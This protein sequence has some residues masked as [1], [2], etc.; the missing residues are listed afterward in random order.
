[1]NNKKILLITLL[2]LS[3]GVLFAENKDN[4]IVVP[5]INN[6]SN[7]DLLVMPTSKEDM[8]QNV[9][10]LKKATK[11]IDTFIKALSPNEQEEFNRIIQQIEQKMT[12]SDSALDLTPDVS[13]PNESE[14]AN[15]VLLLM[16]RF[17]C[18]QEGQEEGVVCQMYEC[19]NND[20]QVSNPIKINSE[21]KA[22]NDIAFPQE[23]PMFNSIKSEILTQEEPIS[24]NSA[25]PDVLTEEQPT[26][27][28]T[29]SE[30]SIQE[31]S[32]S[33]DLTESE[34]LNQEEPMSTDLT[35]PETL[36]EK[37]T[38]NTDITATKEENKEVITPKEPEVFTESSKTDLTLSDKNIMVD[39]D[40]PY[41]NNNEIR[42]LE[43]EIIGAKRR[44]ERAESDPLEKEI[45]ER[46]SANV[47]WRKEKIKALENADMQIKD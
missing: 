11:E 17:I 46:A 3:A 15:E 12:Q 13:I 22:T 9:Q 47:Q 37:E 38:M 36:T 33:T 6:E 39:I 35:E 29:E 23:K 21:Q 32:M 20:C 40:V 24:I 4:N 18:Q 30:M 25:E 27:D 19:I 5:T 44:C 2:T 43:A 10:E 42:K 1:M 16:Q 28:L 31:E 7:T 26:A 41:A 45:C 8:N 14:E 34:I